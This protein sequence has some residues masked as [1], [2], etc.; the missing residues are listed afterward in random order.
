MDTI[1]NNDKT[2]QNSIYLFNNL[3][4]VSVVC[5]INKIPQSQWHSYFLTEQSWGTSINSLKF[6]F[7]ILKVK[8][9]LLVLAPSQGWHKNQRRSCKPWHL[10]RASVRT[11]EGHVSCRWPY[12][13]L[14][15]AFLLPQQLFWVLFL[16]FLL[17][18]LLLR[19]KPRA[20][21]LPPS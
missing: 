19:T 11:K 9:I 12:S 14:E 10:H 1:R 3:V 2:Q 8:M 17:F 4:C 18:Y 20:T 16:V 13:A 6:C 21:A 5:F 15:R 7:L